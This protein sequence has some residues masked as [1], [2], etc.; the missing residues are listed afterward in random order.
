W[1]THVRR[2]QHPLSG[3]SEWVEYEGTSIVRPIWDGRG[4]TVELDVSGPAGRIEGLS[5]RLYNPQSRQWSLNYASSAGGTL[6]VPTVGAFANRRGEFY[7]HESIDG[8]MVLVR[9]VITDETPRSIRFEQAYSTDGG[10][11]WETNWVAIDT[12]ADSMGTPD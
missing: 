12:P 10:K 2:L 11:T 3:S 5:L 7:D 1:K 9:N 8:R 6:G 4:N